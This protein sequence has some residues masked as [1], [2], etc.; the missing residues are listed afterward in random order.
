MKLLEPLE[1]VGL[2]GGADTRDE[3]CVVAVIESEAGL[4]EY[5]TIKQLSAK[6]SMPP[7]L[8]V[9]I[10]LNLQIPAGMA[11][12]AAQ[13]LQQF[14]AQ[15]QAVIQQQAMQAIQQALGTQAPVQ[16]VQVMDRNIGW[17]RV[18]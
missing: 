12:N 18:A 9:S 6:R 10:N 13:A 14:L 17:G 4:D 11:P 8:N 16:G 1:P 5:R 2:L 15:N 7:S 3:E